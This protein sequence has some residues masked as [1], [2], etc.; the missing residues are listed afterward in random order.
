MLAVRLTAANHLELLDVPDPKP[1]E[2]EAVVRV[3]AAALNHRDVWIMTGQY[4][5]LKFP[6]TPGSDG[7]GVVESVGSA[8][9][10]AWEGR[11][12]IVN[13]ALGWGGAERS[14]DPATFNILGLPRDG[15]LAERVVAPVAQL[16]AKPPHLSWEE[17]AALPLAGLTAW[18]AV[19][20]R[21]AVRPGERVLITG[22]GGGVATFALIFARACG[23]HVTV[24]S[25]SDEKLV[26]AAALGAAEGVNYGVG[27]WSGR[28][29]KGG[30][31]DFIVDGAGGAGFEALMDLAAPG[32]RI[33]SYGATRGNPAALPL[34]KVFWR[35]VSL[36]GTT[37]GSPSDWRSMVSFVEE[38]RLKP[39][40]SRVYSLK[41]AAEAFELMEKGGQFGK[42][43]VR[44]PED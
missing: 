17:A 9:D 12:V 18:R 14:Q 2:G 15:A 20:V 22:I 10:R 36:L 41:E 42:I 23:A 6:V 25:G 7:A 3:R 24:T 11:E 8:S 34:R 13:P 19:C 39:V 1:S 32:G 5:G 33:V 26:R 4:A 29:A 21:G 31:Y 35:Q 44:V 27:D 37:M 43:V 38:R 28:L 30:L 40:V 16:N